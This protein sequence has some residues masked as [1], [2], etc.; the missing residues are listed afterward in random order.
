M[1][2]A[3]LHILTKGESLALNKNKYPDNPEI[4]KL[5]KKRR[6]GLLRIVF[7][8]FGITALLLLLQVVILVFLYMWFNEDIEY[9]AMAATIFT[10]LVLLHL[11]MLEMESSAKLTW[12]F[13]ITLLPL[14]AA[15]MLIFTENDSG[16]SR[17]SRRLQRLI[18]V[19]KGVIKQD[20]R[21]IKE[22]DVVSTSTDA[23]CRY[24]N[25]SGTFPIYDG[26]EVTYFPLGEYKF[27]AMLEELKKAEKFIFMEYF[28]I[29][30]GLMWV[31]ARYLLLP[32]I[33]PSALQSL[34]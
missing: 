22:E 30:E 19:S 7:S 8:R 4:I 9:F 18:K 1:F 20:E 13:L 6:K 31:C 33:I 23:L 17:M 10:I 16:H 34:A 5:I 25:N 29:D 32:L 24:L 28:I 11:F 27:K 12:M 15:L 26:S 14:P 2:C 21:V 3:A